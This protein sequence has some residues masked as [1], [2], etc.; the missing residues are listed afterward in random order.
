MTATRLSA[1]VPLWKYTAVVTGTGESDAIP[2]IRRRSGC[3]AKYAGRGTRVGALQAHARL[4]K[5]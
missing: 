1:F 2:L 3:A 4:R 5:C